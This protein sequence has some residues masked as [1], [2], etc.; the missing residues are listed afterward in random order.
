MAVSMTTEGGKQ[1]IHSM[2]EEIKFE[3]LG[4]VCLH[5]R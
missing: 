5:A 3:E 2:T 4:K 1:R